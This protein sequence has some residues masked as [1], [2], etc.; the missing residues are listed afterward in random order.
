VLSG[1]PQCSALGLLFLFSIQTSWLK[2]AKTLPRFA[3]DAKS[4]KHI[5]GA[6]DSEKLPNKVVTIYTHGLDYWLLK[7]NVDKCR[8]LSIS[9]HMLGDAKTQP[10]GPRLPKAVSRH[11]EDY[12]TF[13]TF[14]NA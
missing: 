3:D 6:D 10:S 13:I 11:L 14:R 1:I 8:V 9:S 7:L 4:F 5:T 2:H 12:N